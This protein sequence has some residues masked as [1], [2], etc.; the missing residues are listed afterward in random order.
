MPSDATAAQT[1]D[2]VDEG[3]TTLYQKLVFVEDD[4]KRR[5]LERMSDG[6]DGWLNDIEHA[7]LVPYRLPELIEAISLDRIVFVTQDEASADAIVAAG[8]PATCGVMGQYEIL[9]GS[10][11][12]VFPPC[13]DVGEAWANMVAEDLENRVYDLAVVLPDG[14]DDGEDPARWLARGGSLESLYRA[15]DVVDLVP[16]EAPPPYQSK[17][18]AVSPADLFTA[19]TV[20]YRWLI[21]DILPANERVLVYGDTGSGKSFATLDM[22]MSVVRGVD[23]QGKKTKQVGGIYCAFE[24]GKGFRQRVEAYFKGHGITPNVD[25][26]WRILTRPADLFNSPAAL[27]DLQDEIAHWA[28]VFKI[29]LGLIVVD[30]ISASS[31]GMKEEDGSHMGQY[32]ANARSLGEPYGATTVPVHHKPKGGDTPRGSGKLTADLETAIEVYFAP[33]K[34]VDENG[35]QIRECKIIKQREGE[36]GKT[37]RFVLQ[38]VPVGYYEDGTEFRSCFVCPPGGIERPKGFRGFET[39]GRE[40]TAMQALFAALRMQGQPLPPEIRLANGGEPSVGIMSNGQ[41]LA[42]QWAAWRN[43]YMAL[44]IDN[45]SSDDERARFGRAKSAIAYVGPKLVGYKLIQN[46]TTTNNDSWIWWTGKPIKG[47]PESQRPTIAEEA[48]SRPSPADEL[49]PHSSF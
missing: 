19:A 38:G 6:M 4:G 17:F 37:W 41:Q 14:M 20:P 1:F 39:R 49:P 48:A 23:Y 36:A 8:A 9:A 29:P 2:Y 43:A 28:S 18:G 45:A 42:V 22:F 30:T 34:A 13:S 46:V 31:P 40:T 5:V 35:R 21:R 15:A 44:D 12:M 47:I 7:R 26:S 32:L 3:G 27:K 24:G 33:D 11:L 25:D 10:R 16:D